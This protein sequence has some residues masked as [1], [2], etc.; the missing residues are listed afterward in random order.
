MD[1]WVFEGPF[2]SGRSDVLL[3]NWSSL[4]MASLPSPGASHYPWARGKPS[5]WVLGASQG[6]WNDRIRS[7]IVF[8]EIPPRGVHMRQGNP[9]SK[10]GIQAGGAVSPYSHERF[11]PM[12]EL[13]SELRQH[14]GSLSGFDD[15]ASFVRV[16]S[17]VEV[18]LFDQPALR[19][20]Q[21]KIP[22]LNLTHD[23]IPASAFANSGLVDHQWWYPLDRYQFDGRVSSLTVRVHGWNLR[24]EGPAPGS[25]EPARHR[26]PP[27]HPPRMQ[28]VDEALATGQS[29]APPAAEGRILER[30]SEAGQLSVEPESNRP[31]HD[32]KN[33]PLPDPDPELCRAACASDAQCQAFTF[34]KPGPQGGPAHCWLKNTAS[35]AQHDP[36]CVSGARRIHR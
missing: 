22:G 9:L 32:Y 5:G 21:L 16:P 8:N 33:F 12:P 24:M 35:P 23:Q 2:F 4:A 13:E 3:K 1:V 20:K 29:A 11:F 27:A 25:A 26:A 28:I 15:K 36:C 17:N 19:G 30:R 10:V 34:V 31:G 6:H 18:V 14:Y 7:F